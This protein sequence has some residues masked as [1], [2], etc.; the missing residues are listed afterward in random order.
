MDV[1]QAAA[2]A[3]ALGFLPV[4]PPQRLEGGALNHVFRV[5]TAAGSVILKHAPPHVATQ[6][7]IPLDPSRLD[8]EVRALRTVPSTQGVRCPEVLAYDAGAVVAVFEDLGDLPDLGT[9]LKQGGDPSRLQRLGSWLGRLHLGAVARTFANPAVQQTRNRVQYRAIRGWLEEAGIP[10]PTAADHAEQLGE[11]FLKPGRCLIMGDL[12][13]RSILVSEEQLHVIDW[14]LCHYGVP[15]QDLGHL[16]AHLWMLA[17]R[18]GV[19][20]TMPYFFAGYGPTLTEADF[21]ET[22]WHTGCEILARV[23]GPFKAG[24]LYDGLAPDHPAVREA[25]AEALRRLE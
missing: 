17:H 23:L 3:T 21:R 7:S 19:P 1:E 9:W 10:N 2:A 5:W 22:A 13:P 4:Q 6:P 24:Y 11:R 12:W 8:Y 14:E 18:T 25:V 16:A 15:A 20:D